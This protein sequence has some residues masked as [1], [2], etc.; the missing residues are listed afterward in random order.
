VRFRLHVYSLV[1][2]VCYR[3]CW[4][5]GIMK[6]D[7][8]NTVRARPSHRQKLV[9]HDIATSSQ[10]LSHGAATYTIMTSHRLECAL[11]PHWYARALLQF[12]TCS[13]WINPVLNIVVAF[14]HDLDDSDWEK[15]YCSGLSHR[16]SSTLPISPV[17]VG[18]R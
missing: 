11:A 10:E 12:Q 5:R 3:S 2:T 16:S 15:N 8:I 6:T 13:D 4:L 7:R 9:D 14:C 17:P 1:C 18:L